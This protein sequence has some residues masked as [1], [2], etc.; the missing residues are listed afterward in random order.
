MNTDEHRERTLKRHRPGGSASWERQANEKWISRSEAELTAW[1]AND[2]PD[3]REQ[4]GWELWQSNREAN[5]LMIKKLS[6]RY[7]I[8]KTAL[9]I[10]IF[11][12]LLLNGWLNWLM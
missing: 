8:A 12:V 7:D 5:Q 1:F 3:Y 10:I 9:I 4:I 6:D 2:L 11:L